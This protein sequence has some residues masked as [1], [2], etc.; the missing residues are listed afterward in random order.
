MP[1]STG[2]TPPTS[3]TPSGAGDSGMERDRFFN[4]PLV[5]LCTAD[6]HG[7]FVDLSPSWE[8]LLGHSLD[9][10]LS[11]RFL[12]FVHP[13]DREA[14]R[15]ELERLARG[16]PG[17]VLENRYRCA[18]GSY[19][20]LSWTSA[21][22]PREGRIYAAAQDVTDR[23]RAEEA[24]REERRR[25]ERLM[26]ESEARFRAL[27]EHSP[28]AV[29][30]AT[31]EGRTLYANPATI[32]LLELAGAEEI[33]GRPHY[34]FFAEASLDEIRRQ[35][36]LR[37][38]GIASTYEAELVTATGRARH[39]LIAGA[40]VFDEEGRLQSTMGTIV[41]L[42]DRKELEEQLRHS[43]KM[44]S[45]G[46][47]AGGIAHDF[48]NILT[49]ILGTTELALMSA[50][51]PFRSELEDVRD[52][53]VRAA[54]LTNQLLAFSRKQVAVT[55]V[56]DLNELVRESEEMLK[57]MIGSHIVLETDLDGKLPAVRADPAQLDQVL[58][59]LVVN[60]RDAM[61][62]GGTLT[63]ATRA[64][65]AAEVSDDPGFE[66]DGD[67]EGEALPPA[68]RY[69][70]LSVSDTGV[71]MD[72]AVRAQ[73]FDPFFTTKPS[74]EGTGL[75]LAMVYG[76]VKQSGGSVRVVSA[77]DEGSTLEIFL[78]EAD[79]DLHDQPE[80]P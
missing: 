77:L 74:G 26:R 40:P 61:P 62:Q 68:H 41:D 22:F 29:W 44:E 47:L 11:R 56:L 12:D 70:K 79:T 35:E 51:G 36:A 75:G 54:R 66:D 49:S 7:R 23:H 53:A 15:A 46:R 32:E 13:E 65:D 14:T 73:L 50:E 5:L 58:L 10:L 24:M 21:A 59:N 55:R 16:E 39:V 34:E 67:G 20:W 6:L 25:T 78:P 33:L 30:Q 52:S 64:L 8:A 19:R 42:S 3:P 48:N 27:V 76:I 31:P 2:L 38:R 43:Q 1:R 57:R 60:A 63:I 71:G 37:P 28:V 17:T 4:L 69:A 72:A 9:E 18:D 80:A 45:I